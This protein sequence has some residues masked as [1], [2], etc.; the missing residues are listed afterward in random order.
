VQTLAVEK[1]LP[2]SGP[3][4][5]SATRFGVFLLT[6]KIGQAGLGVMRKR[7]PLQALNRVAL[8]IRTALSKQRKKKQEPHTRGLLL[9][10][11]ALYR[12][13]AGKRLAHKCGR[14]YC[15][16]LRAVFTRS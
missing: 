2:L 1:A 13:A 7:G 4:D 12:G 10:C 5:G 15:A 16:Q 11:I 14:K 8:G 3:E 6:G 9:F